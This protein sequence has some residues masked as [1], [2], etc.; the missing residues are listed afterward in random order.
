MEY[1]SRQ[2]K[3][4]KMTN[5]NSVLQ[6]QLKKH[7]GALEN[8]PENLNS[9]LSVVS[10]TYD[11]NDKDRKML[12]RSIESSSSEMKELDN[13]L[14]K[15]TGENSKVLFG[16]LKESLELLIEDNGKLKSGHVDYLKLSH[17]ADLLKNETLK[18]KVAEE[19][20]NF[21]ELQLIYAN[22]IFRVIS[23]INQMIVR[24]DSEYELYKEACKIAVEFGGFIIVWIDLT[25]EG[26]SKSKIIESCDVPEGDL[27]RLKEMT[28]VWRDGVLHTGI[29]YVNNSIKTDPALNS[30]KLWATA[31]GYE[32]C[33]I[34]PIKKSGAIVGSFNLFA[35]ETDFFNSIETE[36]LNEATNDISFA[37]DVFEKDRLRTIAEQKLRA[38]EL[39]LNQAQAIAHFGSWDLDFSTGVSL[40]SEEALR[41]YGLNPKENLQTYESWVSLIHPAD[42]AD[43]LKIVSESQ[44]T[45]SNSSLFC[46]IVRKDGGVRHIYSQSNFEFDKKGKP[47]GMYGVVHDITEMNEVERA[48]RESESNLQAIFENTADGF[49]LTDLNGLVKSFNNKAKEITRLITKQEM[50]IG[51]SSH[52]FVPSP[53]KAN[54]EK[55]ISKVLAGHMLRFEHSYTRTNG[56]V[57]W[58]DFIINPVYQSGEVTGLSITLSDIT[59]RKLAELHLIESEKRYIELFQMSPLPKWVFDQVTLGFLEVNQAAIDHYGYTKEEFLTMTINDI[60]QPEDV[61]LLEATLIKNKTQE[62]PIHRQFFRHQKKNGDKIQVELKSNSILYNGKKAKVIVAHDNTERLNYI[63]AIED[64]NRKLKEIS[65]MQSHVIR[66]PL[67]RI[68]ALIPMISNEDEMPED[69]QLI[70]K[71]LQLSAI[72]LDEVILNITDKTAVIDIKNR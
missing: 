25:S 9:I 66:T 12:E 7:F 16:K 2:G 36:L 53:G 38:S 34:L 20:Q 43:V 14:C 28:A 29:S 35:A 47:I 45:L 44:L 10:D 49:I 32:A 39:R 72:E 51:D 19:E 15:E 23:Q 40:W 17:I 31:R 8:I 70:L 27:S 68:M 52:D 56:S 4:K 6:R 67:A 13:L 59:K 46:R 48:L 54:Y 22:R 58:F 57:K 30:G 71:Y 62:E 5:L 61:A 26:D 21:T 18:R 50:D 3:V 37:L 42:R 55:T 64:Q 65:W 63:S 24:V 60:R 69:K 11:H 1:V 41:I 33:M